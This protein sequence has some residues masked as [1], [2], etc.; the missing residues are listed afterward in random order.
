LPYHGLMGNKECEYSGRNY[1]IQYSYLDERFIEH[2]TDLY[3]GGDP[4][5]SLYDNANLRQELAKIGLD[6]IGPYSKKHF[7]MEII[8]DTYN[9]KYMKLMAEYEFPNSPD[10][11]LLKYE[12]GTRKILFVGYIKSTERWYFLSNEFGNSLID[13]Y[14]R[15]IDENPGIINLSPLCRSRLLLKLRHSSELIVF[16]NSEDDLTRAFILFVP[17]FLLF[18]N[19]YPGFIGLE[20]KQELYFSSISD[21]RGLERMYNS[22]DQKDTLVILFHN[23]VN[24]FLDKYGDSITFG[25]NIQEYRNGATSIIETVYTCS[26]GFISRWE[27]KISENGKILSLN[28][29]VGPFHIRQ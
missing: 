23:H 25:N 21:N 19:E 2:T 6:F 26:S 7:G 13:T 4:T 1:D 5:P 22:F 8:P 10:F 24:D 17:R 28:C 15:M 9:K 12:H 3:Q 18:L 11:V 16:I 20:V 14:N 27:I 29:I